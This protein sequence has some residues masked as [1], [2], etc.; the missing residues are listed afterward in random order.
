MLQSTQLN[1]SR[2]NL[3]WVNA[4]RNWSLV[5]FV[6]Q[7]CFTDC[8]MCV[9]W[10]PFPQPHR[11]GYTTATYIT[12]HSNGWQKSQNFNANTVPF[13]YSQR[14]ISMSSY[15]YISLVIS[16]EWFKKDW[17]DTLNSNS[18]S[19]FPFWVSFF[20]ELKHSGWKYPSLWKWKLVVRNAREL[21]VILGSDF[22]ALT[23]DRATLCVTQG[24]VDFYD[25]LR[26]HHF[27]SPSPLSLFNFTLH[28][29]FRHTTFVTL[30]LSYK[31]LQLL[32]SSWKRS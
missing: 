12:S 31:H 4:P 25:L 7:S 22:V 21:T 24:Y 27:P 10:S 6:E 32:P 17:T 26:L 30:N 15:Q 16:V 8:V 13:R 3:H 20:Q 9:P 2:N 11:Q 18:A 1:S 28:S 29:L 14:H 5:W 23:K 19:I